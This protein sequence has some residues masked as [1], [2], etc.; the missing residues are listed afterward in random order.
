MGATNCPE[1]PRQK[2]IGMMYLVLLAMLAM[3]VAVEVLVAFRMVDSSLVQTY[4]TIEQESEQQ[5]IS[6]QSAY[7]MNKVKVGPWMKQA[8]EIRSEVEELQKYVVDLKEEMAIAGGGAKIKDIDGHV[9][10]SERSYFVNYDG[11][12]ILIDKDDDLNAPSEIMIRM[13]K[14]VELKEK[15]NSLRESLLK[16]VPE[17]SAIAKTI[18]QTLATDDNTTG[19]N[20]WEVKNFANQPMIAAITMLSKIQIDIVNTEATMLGW[21][22]NQIDADSFK[23]NKLTPVVIT[24]SSAVL[25][26]GNYQAQVF[27]AAEDTTQT[28]EIMVGGSLLK[29]ESGKGIYSAAATRAGSYKWGGEIKFKKSDGNVLTYPFEQEYQVIKPSATVSPTKMNVFYMNIA[30]PISVSVPG[31]SPNDVKVSMTNGR[32]VESGGNISVF[33]SAEDVAGKNTK[34]NVDV[35]FEG[36]VKRVASMSFRVKRVPDPVGQI[37]GQN[38][39]VIKKENLVAEQGIF[40]ALVDF[41]FDLRFRVVSFDVTVSGTGGYN[42][43]YKSNSAHFTSQMK[44]QFAAQ[45]PGSIVYFDNIVAKGDDN[46]TRN[47][48]PISF[49]IR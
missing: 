24:K 15:I 30:N 23:F 27:L 18:S 1:T 42:N 45:Q 25:E 11:D 26:G 41:D 37:A 39:G 28:P 7:Q 22:H 17:G 35:N 48:P 44:Q 3:N 33:P 20:S 9:A 43:T 47:L 19:V 31:V 40:A 6:L 14:G 34:I 49:K 8:D 4:M 36:T 16:K 10:S 5:Y 38:G 29:V 21:L 32:I 2:M 12:S 13:K 46:T